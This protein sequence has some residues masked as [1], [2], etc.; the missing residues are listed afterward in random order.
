MQPGRQLGRLAVVE[1][2]RQA[3]VLE[4]KTGVTHDQRLELLAQWVAQVRRRAVRPEAT[5]GI[6]P[7]EP[8]LT[9][10][11]E[12]QLAQALLEV[13]ERAAADQRQRTTTGLVQTSDQG[14]QGIADMHRVR[15]LCQF[16]QGAVQIKKEGP[17]G[18]R[19]GQ[20]GAAGRTCRITHHCCP[21]RS[22]P[23]PCP[24]GGPGDA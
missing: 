7:F 3:L 11:R 21:P 20:G 16:D 24:A 17:V 19:R 5:G 6:P 1:G 9:G 15:M 12:A 10:E 8:V 13:G 23:R 4:Q 14:E 2:E 18:L 22:P